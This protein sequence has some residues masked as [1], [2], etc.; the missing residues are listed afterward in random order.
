MDGRQKADIIT[1]IRKEQRL[2]I[3]LK[4]Q[5]HYQNRTK[6]TLGFTRVSK[7]M[8]RFGETGLETKTN[9]VTLVLRVNPKSHFQR[10]QKITDSVTIVKIVLKIT[11]IGLNPVLKS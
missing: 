11:L 10:R 2:A 7:A 1:K 8:P 5:L 9:T 4:C 6:K 3:L